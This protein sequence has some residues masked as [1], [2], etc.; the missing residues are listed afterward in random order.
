MQAYQ[1]LQKSCFFF[2]RF[3]FS[4]ENQARVVF[5]KGKLFSKYYDVSSY[6][7]LNLGKKSFTHAEFF[8]FSK[9][10]NFPKF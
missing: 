2:L 1:K 9:M 8:R 10:A 6:A 7:F 4:A 3:G 5:V